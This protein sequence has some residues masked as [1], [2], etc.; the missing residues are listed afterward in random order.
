MMILI[1]LLAMCLWGIPHDLHLSKTE[2]SYNDRSDAIEVVMHIY[3]DDLELGMAD[4]A[5]GLYLGT[6]RERAQADSM[7]AAYLQKHFMLT[8]GTDTLQWEFLGKE[9]SD[10]LMAFWCY[11]EVGQPMLRDDL[12][13]YLSLFD[14]LYDDQKNVVELKFDDTHR[15]YALLRR[16]KNRTTIKLP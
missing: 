10:D 7:I 13:V 15:K 16:G 5:E 6:D 9:V 14:D 1:Q 8:T 3:I 2:V 4:M 11:M 12:G